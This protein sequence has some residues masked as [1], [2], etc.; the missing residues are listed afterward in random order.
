M[1]EWEDSGWQSPSI[2]WR[3]CAAM[4]GCGFDPVR[5]VHQHPGDP[6]RCSSRNMKPLCCS[7]IFKALGE[8][9]RENVK[10][11]PRLKKKK[12][13]TQLRT[14]QTKTPHQK[15]KLL[16]LQ[17]TSL[18]IALSIGDSQNERRVILAFLRAVESPLR[19][20][21]GFPAEED[22]GGSKLRSSS[23]GD[24]KRIVN[25]PKKQ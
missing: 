16:L 8:C 3:D 23:S 2:G 10:C 12:K 18:G 25:P 11:H 19:N 20:P 24:M 21:E 9:M 7:H 13:G 17:S 4:E 22:K 15:K 6:L 1:F 14:I 5:S